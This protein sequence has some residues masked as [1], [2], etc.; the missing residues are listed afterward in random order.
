MLQS[1]MQCVWS[2]ARIELKRLAVHGDGNHSMLSVRGLGPPPPHP[3]GLWVEEQVM[4]EEEQ[5]MCFN[6]LLLLHT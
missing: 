1:S 4:E 2:W 5:V 6:D 3:R